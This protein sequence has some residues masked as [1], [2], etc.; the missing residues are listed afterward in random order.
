MKI[1]SHRGYWKTASEKNTTIAFE[2]SFSLRFGTETDIR[3][4]GGKLVISHDI[5]DENSIT[6]EHLFEIYKSYDSQLPL[7]LNIKADGLQAKL[8]EL[9][10]A[11]RIENY[12]VFD[13]SIPDT[14]GYLKAGIRCFTRQSEYEPTPALYDQAAGVWMDSFLDDWI[15]EQ[16]IDLHL[17]AD[18]QVCL[19]SPDLH[20]R[21][22]NPFWIKLS[23]MRI[24][25]SDNIM[26][27]TDNPEDAKEFFYGKN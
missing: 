5:A 14:L 22:H 13:M 20:K 19:V 25:D 15:E 8:K 24:I 23:K 7:A 27:C 2:R 21:Y 16:H 6:V 4:Y 26:L 11:Y 12:F 17:T 10:I 9:L 3:D 1:L 18:K